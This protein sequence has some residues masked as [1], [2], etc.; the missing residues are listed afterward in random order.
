[1]ISHSTVFNCLLPP[2]CPEFF[3][4]KDTDKFF[5]AVV[6]GHGVNLLALTLKIFFVKRPPILSE[7]IQKV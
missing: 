6:I 5:N 2:P 1:M 3:L 4:Y 7:T